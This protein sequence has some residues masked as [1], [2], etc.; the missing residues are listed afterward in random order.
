[1][2]YSKSQTTKARSTFQQKQKTKPKVHCERTLAYIFQVL[3]CKE[4]YFNDVI[5]V[6]ICCRL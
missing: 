1:M 3:R 4:V 5:R 2:V 6:H